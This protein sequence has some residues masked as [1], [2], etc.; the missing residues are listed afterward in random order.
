MTPIDDEVE[1]SIA[2]EDNLGELVEIEAG[3]KF[4]KFFHISW[5]IDT[6]DHVHD[7]S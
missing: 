6:T 7:A 3:A 4:V 5:E 1:R 2:H